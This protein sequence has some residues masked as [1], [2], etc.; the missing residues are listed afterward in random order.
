M[1]MTKK[2]KTMVSVLFMVLSI[3]FTVCLIASNILETKQMVL[4]PLHLTGGLLIFPV[5]Y[6]VNDVVCEIWGYRRVSIL[7]WLG[8]ITNFCFMAVASLADAIPGAP[9]WEN[10]EG[11]HAIFGLTPRIALASFVSFLAGSFVNAYVM[12]RM[13]IADRGKRFPLRTIM[14]TICGE[15]AD[16]LLFFPL[17]FYGVLPNNELPLMM[18]SQ[19][20]LKTVY[21]IIVLP[22]TIRVVRRVKT[23]EGEDTYDDGISYNIFAVFTRRK[24]NPNRK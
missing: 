3:V 5:S 4:G 7:I 17:A 9:Y 22:V 18:L 11:F 23:Y 8:F 20:V 14:S 19:L 1:D 6:I 10:D 2:N 24:G 12:S 13:K 15:G 16:S 21:E